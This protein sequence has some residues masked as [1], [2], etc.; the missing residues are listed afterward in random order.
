MAICGFGKACACAVALPAAGVASPARISMPSARARTARRPAA[1]RHQQVPTLNDDCGCAS[2][3]ALRLLPSPPQT[4]VADQAERRPIERDAR[5]PI[6][7]HRA[8]RPH[9]VPHFPRPGQASTA[10]CASVAAWTP[11]ATT[12]AGR[13]ALWT[14]KDRCGQHLVAVVDQPSRIRR[15]TAR[16]SRRYGSAVR[17]FASR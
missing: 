13:G 2:L 14:G 4:P 8:A 9:R 16:S 7:Y 6:G 1:A 11:A 15:Q 10:W 5:F 3:P 17:P 12:P